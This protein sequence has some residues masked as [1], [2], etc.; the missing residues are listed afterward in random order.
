EFGRNLVA[1]ALLIAVGLL[2]DVV[3]GRGVIAAETDNDA[4]HEQAG[5]DPKRSLHAVLLSKLTNFLA[6]N[7]GV[8]PI[9]DNHCDPERQRGGLFRLA[10]KVTMLRSGQSSVASG[11]WSWG[12]LPTDHGLRT[13]VSRSALR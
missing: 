13:T 9:M 3:D 1:Q 5:N 6:G 11:Q 2:H 10:E 4:R 12:P 8:H 7:S